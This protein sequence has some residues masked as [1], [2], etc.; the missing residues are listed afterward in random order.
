MTAFLDLSWQAALANSAVSAADDVRS[1]VRVSRTAANARAA[2]SSAAFSAQSTCEKG[3]FA[4]IDEA[5]A[6]QTRASFAQS[7]AIHA[8]VVEHE[9][10]T[11]K[12]RATLALAHDVKTWNVYRKRELLLSCIALA[13]SQHEATRRS[14]DAWSGLR[15]GFIGTTVNPSIIE[16]ATTATHQATCPKASPYRLK[17]TVDPGEVRATIYEN[18]SSSSESGT[19]SPPPIV[20]VEH[21]VLNAPSDAPYLRYSENVVV[22]GYR[23]AREESSADPEL[24]LPFADTC[25]IPEEVNDDLLS[26]GKHDEV[27]C[28]EH[29]P[30]MES[31]FADEKM[32]ASMLSLVDGLMNW[33]GGMD[34]EEDHLALP[35]GM[36]TSIALEENAMGMFSWNAE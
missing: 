36:A 30:P 22:G 14:V 24:I 35:V 6:A 5:R 25:P 31:S 10:K 19:H 8:A 29:E 23:S 33:G 11:V 3:D 18:Q 9:A 34:V 15:D 21:N 27:R 2:A 12:R 32:S 13:R 4:N 26:F 28:S 7:H 20:P 16:R 1:A 17:P